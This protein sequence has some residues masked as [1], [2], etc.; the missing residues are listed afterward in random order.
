MCTDINHYAS[1][2]VTLHY[3]VGDIMR[4]ELVKLVSLP[5]RAQGIAIYDAVIE[6]WF[7]VVVLF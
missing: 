3:A 4:E 6:S 1:L 5:G 7:F 2:A